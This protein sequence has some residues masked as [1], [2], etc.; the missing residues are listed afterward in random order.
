MKI[1]FVV[2]GT[3]EARRAR[4]VMTVRSKEHDRGFRTSYHDRTGASMF[5]RS[6]NGE[7]DDLIGSRRPLFRQWPSSIQ[8][9]AVTRT[10][11]TT[12]DDDGSQ[13]CPRACFFWMRAARAARGECPLFVYIRE[14]LKT[15]TPNTDPN[16]K[17]R[18]SGAVGK[19]VLAV[20]K[21]VLAQ[22]PGFDGTKSSF[23]KQ[24]K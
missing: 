10:F 23:F 5:N 13:T 19:A 14:N 9:S 15:V 11:E 24:N 1:K 8:S 20:G 6:N 4:A 21:A 3:I 16:P 12:T 22:D 7:H 18:K 17:V 2:V